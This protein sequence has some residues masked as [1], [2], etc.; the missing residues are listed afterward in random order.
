MRVIAIDPGFDRIG[1]AVLEKQNGKEILLYSNCFQ[2]N[3]KDEFA[4]RL[5]DLAS[6]FE[7]IAAQFKPDV[8][9]I[10]KLFFNTNQKTAMKVSEARGALID[11]ANTLGLK[12]AEYTPLEIKMA[13]TSYGA[14]S[15]A[16]V[17]DMVKRLLKIEHLPKFDDEFDAIACGLTHLAQSKVV[18]R[19]D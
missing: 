13:V 3:R 4:K 9:A 14:A 6:N 12:I 11:R 18:H 19:K 7:E 8:L 5:S 15:K 17:A 16:Q 1:L 2:T 10:E